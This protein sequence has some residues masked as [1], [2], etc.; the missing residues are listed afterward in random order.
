MFDRKDLKERGKKAFK[1]NYW[2]CVLVSFIMSAIVSLTVRTGANS[3]S[4]SISNA[5]VTEGKASIQE[6]IN[7]IQNNKEAALIIFGIIMSTIAVLSA[8]TT[9]LDIFIFN[10]FKMGK[11]SFYLKN[12]DNS[13]TGISEIG[14]GFNPSYSRNILALFLRRLFISLWS[15]LFLIPGIMKSYSYKMVPYILSEDPNIGAMDALKKSQEMM[16]G[17]RWQAFLL[18][19]SFIGWIFLGILTLGILMC[20]YVSPYI[21]ATKAELYKEIKNQTV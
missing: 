20:F 19:L 10:P 9:L 21:D 1:A 5:G 12:S 6:L 17:K 8:V 18:D 2:M 7:I 13:N 16:K 4:N 11:D 3:T 15:L 14:R